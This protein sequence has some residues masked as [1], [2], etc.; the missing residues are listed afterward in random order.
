MQF[1]FNDVENYL[2][3]S[4]DNA[5]TIEVLREK[6]N[7]QYKIFENKNEK[8]REKENAVGEY[9]KQYRQRCHKGG[10]YGHKPDDHWCLENKKEH[11]KD[12]KTNKKWEEVI[13]WSM[14]SLWKE[15]IYE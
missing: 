14:L 15:R 11:K 2:K 4:G 6:L 3:V 12:E 1:Y 7:H 10:K 9:N 8:K 13:W 5:L